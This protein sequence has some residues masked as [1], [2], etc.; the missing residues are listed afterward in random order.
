MPPTSPAAS[1]PAPWRSTKRATA[2]GREPSAMRT[3]N[4]PS[5]AATMLDEHRI[6][7]DRGEQQRQRAESADQHRR[8]LP[9]YEPLARQPPSAAS[10]PRARDHRRAPRARVRR[11]RASGEQVA[12]RPNQVLRLKGRVP[13]RS[14]RR[15]SAPHRREHGR[16][17]RRRR[18]R[19]PR[20]AAS[21][22]RARAACARRGRYRRARS[23]ARCSR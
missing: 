10:R 1:Q 3:A 15:P 5:R 16:C 21:C 19:R 8:Q 13:A 12:V 20:P 22:G 11:A 14:A 9:A 7:A 23:G 2:A 6:D 18:C 17:A 4:S